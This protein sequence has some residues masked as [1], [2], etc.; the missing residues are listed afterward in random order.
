MINESE[1]QQPVGDGAG[2]WRVPLRPSVGP[3]IMCICWQ[4]S[5]HPT[6]SHCCTAD[7][8]GTKGKKPTCE[9]EGGRECGRYTDGGCQRTFTVAGTDGAVAAL[10]LS[11]AL[12]LFIALSL[13]VSVSVP[14]PL[15]L[16]V[17]VAGETT[18]HT[19]ERLD[20]LQDL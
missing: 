4:I 11:I 16:S 2:C 9:A 13:T 5:P 6:P 3:T 20:V 18:A 19:K 12:T 14:P 15:S 7:G 8:S 10:S 1:F 17:S